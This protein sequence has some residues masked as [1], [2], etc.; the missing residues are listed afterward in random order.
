MVEVFGSHQTVL[1][2]EIYI[3][4]TR[5]KSKLNTMAETEDWLRYVLPG[6]AVSLAETSQ[7]LVLCD[8]RENVFYSSLLHL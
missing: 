8:N 6:P 7:Y 2:R 3:E 4:S 1:V 5:L